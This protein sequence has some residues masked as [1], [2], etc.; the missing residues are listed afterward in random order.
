MGERAAAAAVAR[1]RNIADHT[2]TFLPYALPIR[3]SGV[4]GDILI[5]INA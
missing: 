1:K 4:A 3:T 5:G 2:D